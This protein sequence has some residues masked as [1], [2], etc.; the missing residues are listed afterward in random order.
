M[1]IPSIRKKVTGGLIDQ[2][3][4]MQ[5][6]IVTPSWAIAT[7]IPYIVTDIT[8]ATLDNTC[9]VVVVVAEKGF[10]QVPSPSPTHHPTMTS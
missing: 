10:P 5:N 1:L 8:L 2:N 9:G 4:P 6:P 3:S 7:P